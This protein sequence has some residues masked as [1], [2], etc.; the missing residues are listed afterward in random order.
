MN[1]SG[2]LNL[3]A[4]LLNWQVIDAE[5][6]NVQSPAPGYYTLTKGSVTF[7]FF[8]PDATHLRSGNL[9]LAEPAN[10]TQVANQSGPGPFNDG[11]QNALLYNWHTQNWDTITFEVQTFSTADIGSYVGPG[12]RVLIQFGNQDASSG[13]TV[14]GKPSLN[15]QGVVGQ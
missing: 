1:Y 4:N 10:V 15:L 14:F 8:L 13:T 5:G 11:S 9:I 7:E 3:P 2:T 12:G 6:S